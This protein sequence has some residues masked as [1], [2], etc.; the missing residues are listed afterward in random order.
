MIK[1]FILLF[2]IQPFLFA[3]CAKDIEVIAVEY[4]PFTTK[5]HPKGGISFELLHN[6]S[7][8]EDY[9]WKPVF[10]P[11]KRAYKTLESGDW[12]AS[13]YPAQKKSDYTIIKLGKGGVN[14]GLARLTESSSFTWSSL[15]ELKG[16]TV[17]MMRTGPESKFLTLFKDAGMDVVFVET[18][19]VAIM[20]VL[21][22]R[23]DLAMI[24]NI[25]YL[26]LSSEQ[27]QNLQFSNTYLDSINLRLFINNDCNLSFSKKK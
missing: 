16:S 25:S 8:N 21:L 20:M 23:V 11:P 1:Y 9:N 18:I 27:R 14:I 12:C 3:Y 19:Q 7:L 15:K 17:V 22:N 5:D 6:L 4:P 2:L 24:D 13:F 10:L 26:N